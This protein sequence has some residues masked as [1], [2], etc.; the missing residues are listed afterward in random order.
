MLK[1]LY[2]VIQDDA[3]ARTLSIDG[4]Q[5]TTKPVVAVHDPKPETLVVSTLTGMVDYLKANVD[6]LDVAALLCHVES[7]AQVVLYSGLT[8][9][10]YD[11]PAYLK[12]ELRQL[13]IKLNTY[14]DGESFNI[15]LQSCFCEP[16]DGLQ[17]TDRG[18]VLKYIANIKNT[19]EIGVKD[20]GVSQGVTVK[21]GIASVGNAVLPNPV[22]LR[23]YRTFTEVEQP[24]SRFVFRCKHDDDGMKYMLAE[25]DGGAWRGE[26]MRNV[27]EYLVTMVP[28][29]NVIA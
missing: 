28:G 9:K 23:P 13:Q 2:E 20:D 7:P 18:L 27:K 3:H 21:T 14:I 29:L 11:R 26:A 19:S 8:G 15:L 17:A 5:Y 16:D 24:A 12:A 1:A 4:R 6:K 25:A 10:F 22:T